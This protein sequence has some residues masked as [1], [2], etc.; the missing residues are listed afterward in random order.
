MRA[1]AVGGFAASFPA[2]VRHLA[3]GIV[4]IVPFSDSAVRAFY[5]GRHDRLYHPPGAII[6][7]YVA[8]LSW[9]GGLGVG[10]ADATPAVINVARVARA[11]RLKRPCITHLR[12]V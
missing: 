10:K 9:V 3:D 8:S 6:R 5:P 7:E 2:L 4:I 12:F 1:S 11:S